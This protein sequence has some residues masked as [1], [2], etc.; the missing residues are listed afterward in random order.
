MKIA[1]VEEMRAMDQAAVETYGIPESLLMEN[2]GLAAFQIL[3]RYTPITNRSFL[4]LCGGGNNGGDGLVV[5]RKIHSGGG[6]VTACLL[7]DPA[8]YKNAARL[9]YDIA[10]RLPM[11]LVEKADP[12]RVR[13]EIASADGIIDAIFGTGLARNVEGRYAEI[14]DSVNQSGKPVLSLD[15]PS[16]IQ[17]DTGRIMGTAIKAGRTVTF[18]LPKCGN[19]LYPGFHRCGKLFVT[20]ISFPPALYGAESLTLEIN[21]PPALPPRD[22][23]GHK[24]TFG[25]ALFIAGA[26][27]YIGA[28]YLASCAF[29]KA[30]GGYSRLATPKHLVPFIAAKASE[31]VFLPQSE[32]DAGSI[33]M[34]N[35][36][37]LAEVAKERDMVVMGPGLSL[38]E[39]TQSL[40]RRLTESID[41][42]LLLDGDGLTATAGIPD[43]LA[44][45]AAPTVLTPHLGEMARITGRSV[46]DIRN[47]PIDV[48]R[49]TSSRL[50]AII[51][52]KGPH[53]MI[54]F[55]DGRIYINMSGNSGMA[56]AGSGDV[57][58]GTIAAMHGLGC[59]VEDAVRL[60]V[61]V[62]GL[63]G[64]LAADTHGP[65]GMT[66]EAILGALGKAVR[67]VREGLPDRFAERYAIEEVA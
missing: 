63:A 9:N 5:A 24:G 16:G 50:R 64:D 7:S 25:D 59:A 30:G 17:G 41:R 40:V 4:V 6:T 11:N 12:E 18:G 27:G 1:R 10:K 34:E 43:I 36:A 61:F 38:N 65:D 35:E 14:I 58:T 28:P 42:P 3:K 15:I 48:L 62:H 19:L 55:P 49:E 39:E 51:V 33:S 29:L 56:T 46:E 60:G 67:Y 31:M 52:L 53:S 54:G 47:A 26:A 44:G 23:M 37:S 8:K 2:A 32:T 21:L 57:L 66:A 20:H 13:K 45:R 22:P